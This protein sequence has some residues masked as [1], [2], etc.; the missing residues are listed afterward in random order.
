MNSPKWSVTG[1]ELASDGQPVF[2]NGMSRRQWLTATAV[3]RKADLIA[4]LTN[5]DLEEADD[6]PE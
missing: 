2:A 6:V 1:A 3:D 4:Q 5:P